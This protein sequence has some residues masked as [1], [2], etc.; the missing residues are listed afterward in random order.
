MLFCVDGHGSARRGGLRH[1][2]AGVGVVLGGPWTAQKNGR[3]P[4]IDS[5]TFPSKPNESPPK[6]YPVE[7]PV[8]VKTLIRVFII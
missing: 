8:G 7:V 1:Y 3:T 4:M 2:L 5:C 6:M